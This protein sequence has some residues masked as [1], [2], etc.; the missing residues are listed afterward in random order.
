MAQNFKNKGRD[1][2]KDIVNLLEDLLDCSEST[3]A[4][5]CR[6]LKISSQKDL[7]AYKHNRADILAMKQAEM[8]SS[9]TDEKLKKANMRDLVWSFGVLYDKERLE[10]GQSTGNLAIIV[11]DL[12]ATDQDV[13]RKLARLAPE[14]VKE[15]EG[16]E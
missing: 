9:I 3:I 14:M 4:Y 16:M 13:L 15:S 5:H 2:H 7:E 12:S 8:T 10:R 1:I 11:D 6:K